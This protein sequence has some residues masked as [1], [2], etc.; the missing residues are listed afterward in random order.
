[1]DNGHGG[2]LVYVT[3]QVGISPLKNPIPEKKCIKT[4]H[5]VSENEHF[6]QKQKMYISDY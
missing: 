3:F 1:M 4:E 6:L 2:F 5:L